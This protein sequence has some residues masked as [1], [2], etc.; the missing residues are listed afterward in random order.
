[1]TLEKNKEA[2]SKYYL[3]CPKPSVLH[4]KWEN[5]DINVPEWANIPNFALLLNGD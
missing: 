3:S 4:M 5:R 2:Q 1:M